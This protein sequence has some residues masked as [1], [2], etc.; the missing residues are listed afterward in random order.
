MPSSNRASH[1]HRFIPREEVTEVATWEFKP[2]DGSAPVRPEAPT[3]EPALSADLLEKARHEAHDQGFEE[4]RLAG[5]QEARAVLENQMEAKGREL[6]NRVA[7]LMHQANQHF[8]QLEQMLAQ[9]MLELA[10]DLARQVVRRE[11]LTP[12]EAI[13]AVVRESLALAIDDGR[14]AVLRVHPD[15]AALLELGWSQQATAPAGIRL[16]PDASLTP[17]GCV[18]ESNQGRVDARVEKRWARAV[19]NLGLDTP[20]Q[21]GEDT[22]V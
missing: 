15:D 11:L 18:V 4:G 6:A 5:A 8:D 2:V 12:R 16:E 14:P 17:G 9:H 20:W 21:P 19:A 22:G 10:C 13:E 1:Y 7:G 3:E